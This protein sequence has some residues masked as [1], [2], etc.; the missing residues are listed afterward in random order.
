MLGFSLTIY[1]L[2]FSLYVQI[3]FSSVTSDVLFSES[4][5]AL[6][7]SFRAFSHL[8]IFYKNPAH[9]QLMYKRFVY[10]VSAFVLQPVPGAAWS[11][12]W[13]SGRSFVGIAGSNPTGA[14]DVCL[15]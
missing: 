1:L 11:K 15:L 14:I 5:V 2:A 7:V 12:A 9:L 8:A 13:F 3:I 6:M 10:L 4:I